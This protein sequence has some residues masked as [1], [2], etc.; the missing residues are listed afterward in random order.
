MFKSTFP[1]K[2]QSQVI[3]V[4]VRI[5]IQGRPRLRTQGRSQRLYHVEAH[6]KE[7]CRIKRYLTY[8]LYFSDSK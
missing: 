6:Q 2:C 7:N 5:V 1:T 8:L 4:H 3:H